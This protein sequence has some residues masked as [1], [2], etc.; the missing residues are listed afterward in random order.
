MA[1]AEIIAEYRRQHQ[2]QALLEKLQDEGGDYRVIIVKHFPDLD[3]AGAFF[4]Q[5]VPEKRREMYTEAIE[6]A[7]PQETPPTVPQAVKQIRKAKPNDKS[8]R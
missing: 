8:K 2:K 4:L 5:E 7:R 3:A 6:K 1:T